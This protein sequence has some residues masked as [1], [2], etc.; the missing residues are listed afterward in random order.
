MVDNLSRLKQAS[1]AALRAA[2][3]MDRKNQCRRRVVTGDLS[4][5]RSENNIGFSCDGG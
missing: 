4:T 2:V 5:R 3:N 1:D